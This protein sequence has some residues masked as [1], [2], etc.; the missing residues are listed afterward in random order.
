[1]GNSTEVVVYE[2]FN[3]RICSECNQKMYEGFVIDDGIEYYCSENCLHK[4]ISEEDYLELYDNGEGN[5]YWTIFDETRPNNEV[6]NKLKELAKEYDC[7]V[8]ELNYRHFENGIDLFKWLWADE[9]NPEIVEVLIETMNINVSDLKNS[10][11]YNVIEHV[12]LNDERCF[13]LTD[14]SWLFIYE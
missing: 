2:D 10:N 13:N 14:H 11:A 7:S 6:L 5:S 8:D 4:N 1:M 9:G 3:Y 12:L